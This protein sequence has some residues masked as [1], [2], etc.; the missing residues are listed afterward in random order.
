MLHEL[1]RIGVQV[2]SVREGIEFGSPMGKAMVAM[3]GILM[4]V[5]KDLLSERIKSALQTKKLI[6]ERT[7]SG[8]KAGRPTKLTPELL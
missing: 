5:E 1:E 8:W 2:I 3:I 6:A 4:T 7:G